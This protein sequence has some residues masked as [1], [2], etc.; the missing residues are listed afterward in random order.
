[1]SAQAKGA[2][3]GLQGRRRVAL[4][5][6]DACLSHLTQVV[7]VLERHGFGATFYVCRFG[8]EWR[9]KNAPFQLSAAQVKE[10]HDQGFRIGNHTW[11]HGDFAGLSPEA[12]EAEVARLNDWLAAAGVPAPE[13]FAYPG[14]PFAPR[15]V[16]V[17]RRHGL[18]WAREVAGRAWAP[19]RDDP[20]RVP[21]I[22]LQHDDRDA[23]RRAL[24][25]APGEVP[26]LV[27]HGVPDVVHPWVDTSP[28]FFAECMQ[29]L[30][31]AGHE[32]LALED[33]AAA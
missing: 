18:R 26:V 7:P 30:A 32:V 10:I 21:S 1:M 23:F 29:W 15:A 6:D 24:D 3:V 17:L 11:S 9:E 16:E 5:F 28:R 2:G 25:C 8:A 27:F 22:A 20:L 19:G 13:S 12:A 33:C 31:D 14:G 4:T